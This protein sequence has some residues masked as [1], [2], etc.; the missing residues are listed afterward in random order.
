MPCRFAGDIKSPEGVK[1]T[2]EYHNKY[3]KALQTLWDTNKL[4]F[5]K[6]SVDLQLVE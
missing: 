3:V 2:R 5:S 4:K 1:L 6:D